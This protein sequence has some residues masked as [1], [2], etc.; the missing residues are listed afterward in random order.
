MHPSESET[1]RIARAVA[2]ALDSAAADRVGGAGFPTPTV[3][4]PTPLL[5]DVLWAV[6]TGYCAGY[7]M[8]KVGRVAMIGFGLIFIATQ[9]ARASN[10]LPESIF[11]AEVVAAVDTPTSP[12]PVPM[13]VSNDVDLIINTNGAA[14]AGAD[15][16]PT[17]TNLITP[18]RGILDL[19]SWLNS[20]VRPFD[21]DGDGVVSID[22]AKN[23]VKKLVNALGDG[24]ISRAVFTAALAAGIRQG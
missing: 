21:M 8:K 1:T 16:T 19:R 14:G 13:P 24:I 15:A 7:T 22:D 18:L 23:V 12:M 10:T 3:A 2:A 4:N 6:V 11:E 9:I 20:A 17:T 5:N